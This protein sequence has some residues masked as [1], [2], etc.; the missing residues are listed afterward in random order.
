MPYLTTIGYPG[1]RIA[2]QKRPA[3][4]SYRMRISLAMSL[5]AIIPFLA[6]I[7]GYIAVGEPRLAQNVLVQHQQMLEVYSQQLS[8]GF[9]EVET[10]T[11]HVKNNK[12]IR[13]YLNRMET[14]DMSERLQFVAQLQEIHSSIS[15]N[16]ERLTMRVYSDYSEYNY[17]GYCYTM[18]DLEDSYL[19]DEKSL[20]EI[21]E[22][23]NNETLTLLRSLKQGAQRQIVSVY[24]KVDNPHGADHILEISMPI[25]DMVYP[26]QADLPGEHLIGACFEQNGQQYTVLLLGN[27]SNARQCLAEYY[28]TG[29]CKGYYP[30][31]N[32]LPTDPKGQIICLLEDSYVQML[33]LNARLPLLMLIFVLIIMVLACSYITS[34]L[35]TRK[36]IQFIARI[37]DD[38]RHETAR[39]GMTEDEGKD[40]ADIAQHVRELSERSREQGKQLEA[41]KLEKK[42]MELELLQMRFNPHFLYNTLGS[43][44]YQVKDKRIIQSIDSLIAYY[45]I[46]LSKGSLVISIESEI[47]MIREYLELQIFAFNLQNFSYVLEIE[48]EVKGYTIIKHLLQPI[49]ENAL[50]HGVR[51]LDGGAT[52][53][54]RGRL[55]G[56]NV[57][58]EVEDTGVGMTPEQ[59][60]QVT[61]YPSSSLQVGGYG[62]YNAIQRI[63][64][65]Y[66]PEYGIEYFSQLGKGTLARITIPKNSNVEMI[67]M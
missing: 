19:D 8:R 22:I 38:L 58:L 44:R 60:A 20:T 3:V 27:Q 55:E 48:D 1:K 30:L 64:T 40:L 21:Y 66:G 13:N 5:F 18:K 14:L 67:E 49:V 35:L 23:E 28:A 7:I 36:V 11:L 43:I 32:A 52:I 63:K 53:T 31:K 16:S 39:E 2:M 15:V 65:Y 4:L 34:R 37:E 24:T 26:A 12:T 54:I 6:M 51:G 50:D 47:Q 56:E 59:I 42:R 10:K 9:Q 45:R 17:G 25:A 46:V 61:T 33:F 62:V 29:N 57:V 41:N